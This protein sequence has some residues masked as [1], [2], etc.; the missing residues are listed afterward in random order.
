L[1]TFVW[2][3]GFFWEGFRWHLHK[4]WTLN[5]YYSGFAKNV[6]MCKCVSTYGFTT[7]HMRCCYVCPYVSTC[8][9]SST[10]NIHSPCI[11]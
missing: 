2:P 6:Y 3:R 4:K 9:Y 10:K 7:P 1:D 8:T 5:I 11:R